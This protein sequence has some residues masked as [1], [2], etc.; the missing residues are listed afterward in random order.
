MRECGNYKKLNKNQLDLGGKMIELGI[1]QT[2]EGKE[3][4]CHFRP[5]VKIAEAIGPLPEDIGSRG[6]AFKVSAE[7]EQEAKQNLAKEIGPG[8]FI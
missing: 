3:Y 4:D 8:K 5:D 2:K 1:Y 7:S 6:V